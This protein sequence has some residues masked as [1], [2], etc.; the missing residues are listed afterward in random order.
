[1][2]IEKI[3]NIRNKS[4]DRRE[5]NKMLMVL[6]S[7]SRMHNMEFTCGIVNDYDNFGVFTLTNDL[8]KT[9][10]KVIFC[11]IHTGFS[12]ESPCH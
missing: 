12:Y 9:H 7:L 4:I 8:E 10:V 11:Y 6:L 3:M 2:A 5:Y 1:M